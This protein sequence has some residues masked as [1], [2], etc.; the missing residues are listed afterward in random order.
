MT[1]EV[2]TYEVEPREVLGKKVKR[3]RRDGVLPANLYGRGLDSVAIQ[4][5]LQKARDM[6][7]THG[8]NTLINVRVAGENEPRP[9]IVRDIKRHPVSGNVL[10]V[11]FYQVD[12]TRTLKAFVPINLIGE[13]VAVT[14]Q[15][16]IMLQGLDT[17]QLEA[18][19]SEMPDHLEISVDGL[20]EIDDQITVASL[21]AAAGVTILSDSEQMVARVTRPRLIEEVDEAVLEGEEELAEGEEAPEGADEDGESAGGDSE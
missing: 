9:V 17:V 19:P 13:S 2:D 1:S 8:T 15:G 16:G 14:V 12:L 10:H 4:M 11:D 7:Y 5:P 18:L 6:L 21:V 3:L 20:L